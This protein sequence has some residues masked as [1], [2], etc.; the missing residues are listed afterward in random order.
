MVKSLPSIAKGLSGWR[1]T[2][3]WPSSSFQRRLACMD[4]GRSAS[5]AEPVVERRLEQAA[6]ESRRGGRGGEG[7]AG[8]GGWRVGLSFL[9]LSFP[10]CGNGLCKPL[11]SGLRRNDGGG[12]GQEFIRNGRGVTGMAINPFR[13]PSSFQRRLESRGGVKEWQVLA[14]GALGSYPFSCH[15]HFAGMGYL[16]H[17]IPAFA[18][19]TVEAGFRNSA[20]MVKGLSGWRQTHSDRRRRSSEGGRSPE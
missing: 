18:G 19:M 7:V 8:F 3:S 20:E 16:N 9:W 12:W 17:W 10:L 14:D 1:L 2:H 13:P 15:S 4:A 5:S 11:D 6:E